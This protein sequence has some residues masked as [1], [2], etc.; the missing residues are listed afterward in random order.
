MYCISLVQRTTPHSVICDTY[1]TDSKSEHD[2]SLMVVHHL[3]LQEAYCTV[4]TWCI[5]CDAIS[6]ETWFQALTITSTIMN[7]VLVKKKGSETHA[8]T[9]RRLA[10]SMCSRSVRAIRVLMFAKC[11][12]YMV[13]VHMR[14]GIYTVCEL[15]DNTVA[16]ALRF[17]LHEVVTRNRD[18]FATFFLTSTVSAPTRNN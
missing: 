14:I 12:Q 17:C 6:L 7:T 15:R 3:Y 16:M 2:S 18:Q 13:A 8:N 11:A 9:S 5:Q 4:H 10:R 1:I